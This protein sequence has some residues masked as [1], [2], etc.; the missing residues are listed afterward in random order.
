MV[1]HESPLKRK[2]LPCFSLRWANAVSLVGL[3]VHSLN[4]NSVAIIENLSGP[5]SC[6]KCPWQWF[7]TH[8]ITWTFGISDGEL[9]LSKKAWRLGSGHCCHSWKFYEC[10]LH[11]F[12]VI[13]RTALLRQWEQLAG[14]AIYSPVASGNIL[15]F[16]RG[17]RDYNQDLN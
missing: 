7:S 17:H 11:A 13:L 14:H 5:C 10:F 16:S 9:M 2:W 1:I 3:S 6:T 12:P 4:W 8:L 15:A